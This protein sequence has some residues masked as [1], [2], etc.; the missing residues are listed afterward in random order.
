[1][2][3]RLMRLPVERVGSSTFVDLVILPEG[4][5]NIK[6]EDTIKR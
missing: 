4:W 5:V 6:E 2:K 1:M 3:S